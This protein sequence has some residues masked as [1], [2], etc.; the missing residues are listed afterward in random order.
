MIAPV[1]LSATASRMPVATTAPA[2]SCAR[3][4]METALAM[5]SYTINQV[6]VVNGGI[7]WG[8]QCA[9]GDET[10]TAKLEIPR[11]LDGTKLARAIEPGV[12]G[13]RG[14][15]PKRIVQRRL[16]AERLGGID[17]LDRRQ[18]RVQRIGFAL[19]CFALLGALGGVVVIDLLRGFKVGI[20]QGL[21]A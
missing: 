21:S 9:N 12:K 17:G 13:F 4:M 19:V 1:A 2:N 10:I 5:R 8:T 14:S 16:L 6:K 18:Q 15:L 3:L 20:L 7:T 11:F